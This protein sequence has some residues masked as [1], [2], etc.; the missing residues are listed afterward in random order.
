MERKS[1]FHKFLM[2]DF[3]REAEWL[4]KEAAEGWHLVDTDGATYEFEKGQKG[5]WV[6]MSDDFKPGDDPNTYL[7]K[8]TPAGWKFVCRTQDR[9]YMRQ[10]K[11]GQRIDTSM[12]T[13][14]EERLAFAKKQ[15]K[16]NVKKQLPFYIVGLAYVAL[17]L[18]SDVFD[19]F[20]SV[21]LTTLH[22]LAFIVTVLVTS[23]IG[24]QMNEFRRHKRIMKLRANPELNVELTLEE[25]TKKMEEQENFEKMTNL[26]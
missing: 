4:N 12:F 20:P 1:G 5:P 18:F 3:V 9:V 19:M 24:I 8:Y 23:A 17:A 10:K 25:A 22:V 16:A 7:D 15:M 14:E 6:Y 13:P 2:A 21:V 11:V 26:F